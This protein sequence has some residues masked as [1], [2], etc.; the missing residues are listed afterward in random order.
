[1]RRK[2]YLYFLFINS[3][4][5]SQH[6]KYLIVLDAAGERRVNRARSVILAQGLAK[7]EIQRGWALGFMGL[8]SSGVDFDEVRRHVGEGNDLQ[9]A[10]LLDVL[11]RPL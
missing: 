10:K 5:S 11:K 8:R 1:L 3:Q 6:L 7:V 4:S 9:T 2:T